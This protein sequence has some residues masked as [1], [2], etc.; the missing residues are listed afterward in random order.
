MAD[1]FLI[2]SD[3]PDAINQVQSQV[4]RKLKVLAPDYTVDR[5]DGASWSLITGRNPFTPYVV[6]SDPDGA[7]VVIGS[8]YN[9][10]GPKVSDVRSSSSA[11]RSQAI[12]EYCQQLN[13]G[14]ALSIENGEVLITTDWLGLYPIYYF[15]ADNTFVT[16]SIPSLLCCWNGFRPIVDIY[17]LVGILLLAHSCLGH[18]MFKGV[19]RLQ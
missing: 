5:I 11:C 4:R 1:I 8:A 16:T 2:R 19:T 3:N 14:I 6:S 9:P 13:Y 17:G 12:R 7:A 18:T 15:L 10:G